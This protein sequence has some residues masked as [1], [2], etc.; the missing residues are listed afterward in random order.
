MH[1]L[2]KFVGAFFVMLFAIIALPLLELLTFQASY[3]E[4]R[5]PHPG[6]NY[7]PP[8]FALADDELLSFQRDGV[9]ILRNVLNETLAKRMEIAG[10]DL[11]NQKSFHCEAT[12][13]TGPPIFHGY[14]RMCARAQMVHDYLRDVVYTSPLAHVAAQLL[15]A[16]E[17]DTLRNIGDVFMAGGRLPKRWHMD[18]LAFTP[19]SESR[20][21]PCND[22]LIVWMP[23]EDSSV[24]RNGM[25]YVNGSHRRFLEHFKVDP[26]LGYNEKSHF[27]F[28]SETPKQPLISPVVGLGD[29]VVFS[30]CTLH[31]TSGIHQGGLRRAYQLRFAKHVTYNKSPE[32][33]PGV[34]T[35]DVRVDSP[36]VWPH[37][38]PSEDALRS[39]GHVVFPARAWFGRLARSPAFALFT[40]SLALKVRWFGDKGEN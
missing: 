1:C 39:Q 20:S 25:L 2:A 5:S 29:A 4:H 17:G 36:Q 3:P 21:L 26:D 9:L 15:Q 24:E 19:Y 34:P 33:F 12:K 28:V 23:L 30:Q 40:S 7:S 16:E 22:G 10:Q 6:S 18:F 35:A 14:D 32:R 11:V 27:N 13:F 38:L 31:T 37:T 8:V